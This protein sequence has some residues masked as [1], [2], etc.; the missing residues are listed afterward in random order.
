MMK[1]E[2]FRWKKSIGHKKGAKSGLHDSIKV[3]PQLAQVER[4]Q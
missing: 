1:S 4:G 3:N 2:T